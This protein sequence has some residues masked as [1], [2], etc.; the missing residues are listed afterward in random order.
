MTVSFYDK[1]CTGLVAVANG[2]SHELNHAYTGK[3]GS[4]LS[5]KVKNC[6]L[7]NVRSY[8]SQPE[9][10]NP[11]I[12]GLKKVALYTGLLG[13]G[14]SVSRGLARMIFST[15]KIARALGLGTS[16][17]A[18]F[19]LLGTVGTLGILPA[20]SSKTREAIKD[21]FVRPHLIRDLFALGSIPLTALLSFLTG[22]RISEPAKWS[23]KQSANLVAR[24][25]NI[26]RNA[27]DIIK[28][29]LLSAPIVGSLSAFALHHIENQVVGTLAKVSGIRFLSSY[30]SDK[31]VEKDTQE[32]VRTTIVRNWLDTI[33]EKYKKVSWL[34]PQYRLDIAKLGHQENHSEELNEKSRR[35]AYLGSLLLLSG[36]S[37]KKPIKRPKPARV[38]PAPPTPPSPESPASSVGR[39][40]CDST[41]AQSPSGQKS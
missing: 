32:V 18:T 38:H 6:A 28:G 10:S 39:G 37:E 21:F 9:S 22:G 20:C 14:R 19:A 25:T 27:I 17:K 13:L 31:D 29:A 8:S 30:T 5:E 24:A 41:L 3:L 1:L 35:A 33:G 15:C 23:L 36:K 4:S 16:I 7:A 11:F 12:R 26:Y 34:K 2:S 40:S